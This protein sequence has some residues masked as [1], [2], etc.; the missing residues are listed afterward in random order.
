L[1]EASDEISRF[2]ARVRLKITLDDVEPEAP[3]R[4][5]APLSIR[6]DRLNLTIQAATGWTNS[7]LDE[8]RAGDV[9]L[10]M[11][12][13][14]RR[15]GPL[16]ARKAKLADKVEDVGVWLGV[17]FDPADADVEALAKSWASKPSANAS[18]TTDLRRS[19]QGCP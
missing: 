19:T 9:G 14:G 11:V 8:I 15:D 10:G 17:E 4:V 7:Q 2:R 6:L 18:A 1:V 12:D 13:P 16:D 3:R 5:E